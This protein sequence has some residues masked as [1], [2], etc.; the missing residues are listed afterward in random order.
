MLSGSHRNNPDDYCDYA[1]TSL[2]EI[3]RETNISMEYWTK[4]HDEGLSDEVID[5]WLD[6]I[7]EHGRSMLPSSHKHY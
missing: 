3:F 4:V 5:N 7:R 1:S 6:N 2:D